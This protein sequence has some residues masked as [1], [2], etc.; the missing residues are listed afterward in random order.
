MN[1]KCAFNVACCRHDC[2]SSLMFWSCSFAQFFSTVLSLHST[3][4]M[5][6]FFSVSD[7]EVFPKCVWITCEYCYE[8]VFM[9]QVEHALLCSHG[10]KHPLLFLQL[11]WQGGLRYPVVETAL[12]ADILERIVSFSSLRVQCRI[13][14]TRKG[15]GRTLSKLKQEAVILKNEQHRQ[16]IL[17]DWE[18]EEARERAESQE[19]WQWL[20]SITNPQQLLC[21]RET[22]V[23]STGKRCILLVSKLMTRLCSAMS[24]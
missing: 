3:G 18:A 10:V 2:S 22:L 14:I 15:E 7:A 24:M 19:F 12:P 9:Y 23:W 16:D 1:L 4:T 21:G 20:E 17:R 11:H 5:K 8:H 13:L 6:L